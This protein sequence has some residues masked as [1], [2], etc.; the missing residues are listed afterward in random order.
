MTADPQP[1]PEAALITRHIEGIVPQPSR[2]QLARQAGISS[3][4]WA[5]IE[6]GYDQ[7][8]PGDPPQ[9]SPRLTGGS[10]PGRMA[11]ARGNPRDTQQRP[12]RGEDPRR[13]A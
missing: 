10:W 1:P 4:L 6:K 5:K 7:P 12:R 11:A 8:A 2:A 3:A 13:D 9:G